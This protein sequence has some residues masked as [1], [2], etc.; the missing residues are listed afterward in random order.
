MVWRLWSRGTGVGRRGEW[1]GVSVKWNGAE[2]DG[3]EW[4][5]SNL[6]VAVERRRAYLRPLVELRNGLGA[7]LDGWPC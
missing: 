1:G 7:D 3:E 2:A 4:G 5:P 6:A